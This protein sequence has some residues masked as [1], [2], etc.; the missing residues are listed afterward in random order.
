MMNGIVQLMVPH[1]FVRNDD[2]EAELAAGP[3]EPE[4]ELR[5]AKEVLYGS[6]DA[7][8]LPVLVLGIMHG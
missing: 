4:A 2:S 7:I 5:I 1:G 6:Q 8:S 3:V